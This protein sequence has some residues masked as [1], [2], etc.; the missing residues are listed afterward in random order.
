MANYVDPTREQF[1]GMMKIEDDGPIHMLNMLKFRE[2][3]AY[4][5]GHALAGAGLTGAEAYANYGRESGPIFH[6]VGGRIAHR[7]SPKF[8][9]IGPEDELWDA[10]F[11]AEYPSP[12]AFGEMV[13]DPEYQIAVKH[14]QAAV[15]TS[16][17]IRLKEASV[18]ERF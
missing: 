1:G 8:M 11:V 14:R 10:V 17:L 16:R 6:R 4:E 12:A 9:L 13:K 5:D 15:E 2:N 18:G 3:A 7:W